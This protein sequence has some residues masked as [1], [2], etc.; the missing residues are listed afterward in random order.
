MPAPNCRVLS[1]PLQ[2]RPQ[3]RCHNVEPA[4]PLQGRLKPAPSAAAGSCCRQ[5]RSRAFRIVCSGRHRQLVAVSPPAFVSRARARD[6]HGWTR[7]NNMQ[8]CAAS[9]ALASNGSRSRSYG[10]SRATS[11]SSKD[12]VGETSNVDAGFQSHL[13]DKLH[14]MEGDHQVA[15]PQTTRS[16]QKQIKG[17]DQKQQQRTPQQEHEHRLDQDQQQQQTDQLQTQSDKQQRHPKPQVQMQQKQKA[18]RHKSANSL[19]RRRAAAA[20]AAV[21]K[22]MRLTTVARQLDSTEPSFKHQVV[23]PIVIIRYTLR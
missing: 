19:K 17:L 11:T 23:F 5:L 18:P 22:L 4:V 9:N 12:P 1:D 20:T 21:Q 3:Q 6:A 8:T 10:C 16:E 13:S 14:S 7:D 15:S 2:E